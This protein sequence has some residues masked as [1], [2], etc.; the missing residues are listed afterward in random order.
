MIYRT[1]KFLVEAM[2]S[3]EAL[4]SVAA[5]ILKERRDLANEFGK[6]IFQHYNRESNNVAHE[7]ASF[8]RSNPPVVWLDIPPN[9][10]LPL[11][12]ND[13]TINKASHDG[14]YLKKSS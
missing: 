2:N 14:F 12:V 3:T 10:V 9:F 4:S 7:L 6:V 1:Y 11:I 13:V 8:G 5:P